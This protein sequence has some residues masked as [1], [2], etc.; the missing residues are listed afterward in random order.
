LM[1]N[2]FDWNLIHL[3]P[4]SERKTLIVQ[5]RGGRWGLEEVEVGTL[6]HYNF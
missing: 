3:L 4:F 6:A 1:H 2:S 5:W